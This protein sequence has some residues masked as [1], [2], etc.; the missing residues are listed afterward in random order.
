M[1]FVFQLKQRRGF[2][3]SILS[4]QPVMHNFAISLGKIWPLCIAYQIKCHFP[5]RGTGIDQKNRIFICKFIL[6]TQF[7]NFLL[8][9]VQPSIALSYSS[10]VGPCLMLTQYLLVVSYTLSAFHQLSQSLFLTWKFNN[11]NTFLFIW[12]FLK[13]RTYFDKFPQLPWL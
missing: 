6:L 11:V 2:M 4:Y 1:E 3:W 9:S 8:R 5:K 7:Y 13:M 10:Q 12:H